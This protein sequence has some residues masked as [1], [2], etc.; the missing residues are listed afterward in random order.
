MIVKKIENLKKKFIENKIQKIIKNLK[1]FALQNKQI[2]AFYK[3]LCF[4]SL[5][6][7][8]Y[9]NHKAPFALS[10]SQGQYQKIYNKT[11]F[12]QIQ[13]DITFDSLNKILLDKL[14]SQLHSQFADSTILLSNSSFENSENNND[15]YNQY[16]TN[17]EIINNNYDNNN[18]LKDPLELEEGME[19]S[20]RKNIY[21]NL[22]IFTTKAIL[23]ATDFI[24]SI[25]VR[26]NNNDID[27]MNINDNNK[28]YKDNTKCNN[29]DADNSRSEPEEIKITKEI[30]TITQ[31]REHIF[32]AK[33]A[34]ISFSVF[35]KWNIFLLDEIL[36]MKDF[37]AKN[38]MLISHFSV[39]MFLFEVN[40]NNSFIIEKFLNF[41]KSSS[42]IFETLKTRDSSTGHLASLS[43]RD[44]FFFNL[45]SNL[46]F[47]DAK[48]ANELYE[49]L[50]KVYGV[51]CKFSWA[52]Q[53]NLDYNNIYKHNNKKRSFIWDQEQDQENSTN[54]LVN[55]YS[56]KVFEKYLT[57]SILSHNKKIIYNI[58]AYEINL[59]EFP[60][61]EFCEINQIINYIRNYLDAGLTNPFKLFNSLSYVNIDSLNKNNQSNRNSFNNISLEKTDYLVSQLADVEYACWINFFV[62]VKKIIKLN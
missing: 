38:K 51:K 60:Q 32:C 8:K 55:F 53:N 1:N 42:E 50:T 26:N 6:S 13:V 5:N 19:I 31:R 25:F 45:Y 41:L 10:D 7:S 59:Q 29:I 47:E 17:N 15:N 49:Y 3:K 24:T 14:S 36:H 28:K 11:G 44:L 43:N 16:I 62:M 33:Q 34:E 57:E 18:K 39:G 35:I 40:L 20:L 61:I 23:E 12:K 58:F 37:L 48:F 52:K 30:I 56:T 54:S 4:D 22:N 46:T 2:K 21:L 27:N 9:F